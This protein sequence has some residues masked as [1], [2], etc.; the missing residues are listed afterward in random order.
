VPKTWRDEAICQ[1]CGRK[2]YLLDD[3]WC[4]GSLGGI[5]TKKH[6]TPFIRRYWPGHQAVPR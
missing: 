4:H 2:I 3:G 6:I 5:Q 1:T